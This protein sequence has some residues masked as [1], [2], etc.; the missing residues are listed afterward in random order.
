MVYKQAC[1]PTR[2]TNHSTSPAGGFSAPFTLLLSIL[3]SVFPPG[4]LAQQTCTWTGAVSEAFDVAG[5]WSPAVV[6]GP[7]DTAVLNSG[8]VTVATGSTVKVGG[9]YLANAVV[10]C[11]DSVFFSGNMYWSGGTWKGTGILTCPPGATLYLRG[12]STKMLDGDTLLNLGTVSWEGTGWIGINDGGNLMNYGLFEI[13]NNS[14]IYRAGGGHDCSVTNLAGGIIRKS[15]DG[16]TIFGQSLV[17]INDGLFEVLNGSVEI[18]ANGTI[19][20]T[21]EVKNG[22][23]LVLTLGNITWTSSSLLKS[24][25]EVTLGGTYDFGGTFDV[26][27]KTSVN[28][29]SSNFTGTV[30]SLGDTL[31]IS[32]CYLYFNAGDISVPVIRMTSG[33][34]G[35]SADVRA[36][37]EFDWLGGT[38]RDTGS[39]TIP[40]DGKMNISGDE[41]K[42]ATDRTFNNLGTVSWEGNGWIWVS[43]GCTFNNSGLFEIRNATKYLMGGGSPTHFNNLP[44]GIVRKTSAGTTTFS[45]QGLNFNNQGLLDLQ[46]GTLS[47]LT[48]AH[49]TGTVHSDPGTLISI[50]LG[51]HDFDP[52]VILNLQGGLLIKGGTARFNTDYTLPP[53]TEMT[54]GELSGSGTLTVTDTLKWTGGTLSDTGFLNV[55]AGGVFLV[56]GSADKLVFKRRI[57]NAGHMQVSEGYFIMTPYSVIR[58]QGD[59]TFKG[60]VLA[61]VCCGGGP[62]AEFDNLEG[63]RMLADASGGPVTVQGWYMFNEGTVNIEGSTFNFHP[64]Q[65]A[66]VYTQLKGTTHLGGG[67]FSAPREILIK[68]GILNGTGRITGN[69]YNAG[70]LSPGLSDS[71]PGSLTISG[72][73]TQDTTGILQIGIGGRS[74]VSGYDQLTTGTAVLAGSLQLNYTRN[75]SPVPQD[76][77]RVVR[78]IGQSYQGKF[79]TI[80]NLQYEPGNFLEVNYSSNN[81]MLSGNLAGKDVWVQVIGPKYGRPSTSTSVKIIYGNESPDTIVFPLMIEFRDIDEFKLLFD[82]LHFPFWIPWDDPGAEQAYL[83]GVPDIIMNDE[84]G[85]IPLI[86]TIPGRQPGESLPE[87]HE[88]DAELTPKCNGKAELTVSS[89]DPLTPEIEDCL[90]GI[91]GEL[92]G[93]LPGGPCVKAGLHLVLSGLTTNQ[94]IISGEPRSLGNWITDNGWSIAHCAVSLVPGLSLVAKVAQVLDEIVTGAGTVSTLSGCAAALLP[95]EGGQQSAIGFQCVTSK[96]PNLKGGPEGSGIPNYIRGDNP[97]AYAVYFE[98]VDTATAPAQKV[99]IRDTLRTGDWDPETFSFVSISFGDTTVHPPA[100]AH[101][102]YLEVDLRPARDL[103]VG[104]TGSL[105]DETGALSWEFVSLD[106]ATHNPV[107]DPLA[108]FLLP[109]VISPEGEGNVVFI[110]QPNLDLPTGSGIGSPASIVFDNNEAMVTNEWVNHLDRTAPSSSMESL[111]EIQVSG[112]FEL[113]WTGSDAHSGIRKYF[114]YVST[115]G[116]PFVQWLATGETSCMFRGDTCR[117]YSFYILA[118]DSAG[119]REPE[120][121][122][123]V[124]VTI[125]PFLQPA[126]EAAGNAAICEGDS[127]LLQAGFG[128]SGPTGGSTGEGSPAQLFYEWYRDNQLLSDVHGSE[129]YAHTA[130]DY[131]VTAGLSETCS[132]TSDPVTVTV[133]QAPDAVITASV[134]LLETLPGQ[135]AYQW[136]FNSSP[137][138][139]A[140]SYSYRAEVS[141]DYR[142]SVT[143]PNGCTALS[144][145]YSHIAIAIE[146]QTFGHFMVFPNP[147]GERLFIQSGNQWEGELILRITDMKGRIV[148]S[149]ET[150]LSHQGQVLEINLSGLGPGNYN[151]RIL[152]AGEVRNFLFSK[153]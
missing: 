13:N 29:N 151:L 126:L 27:K 54:G 110:V 149:D 36:S 131:S 118:Q 123:E 73:Y 101:D 121:D 97:L 1:S 138:A 82:Y 127:V 145:V 49:Y 146:D 67:E 106:P 70:T 87:F 71:L 72:R 24:N 28:G 14:A 99:V 125:N 33:N 41:T 26:L 2:G 95:Q 113:R 53:G 10:T 117:D 109:N 76:K 93:F 30:T 66:G 90:V 20:G 64:S 9:I 85:S 128:E 112:D 148:H 43:N 78:W 44:E 16:Q 83:N 23:P 75:Y 22:S 17:L 12:S 4:I 105:D 50:E 42:N 133:M 35:G 103:I 141:G 136:Y 130:G 58:N 40:A 140:T 39:I 51:T 37:I 120:K 68:G 61:G 139:G 81:L 8:Y 143:G 84:G 47:L 19:G 147:A 63:G 115:D 96:D 11:S 5:N 3:L 56:S 21:V 65:V 107:T 108:G 132:G 74:P 7:A 142:V 88:L 94:D 6:P 77:F 119:N 152:H 60:P 80:T 111:D 100:Y 129:Y 55:D 25:G 62:D 150:E 59:F 89:G 122:P 15:S 92:M 116:G 48:L 45:Q 46:E 34:L 102:F 38:I 137:I 124:H 144:E 32:S 52:G 114:L 104:I 18:R 79:D 86:I 31:N 135:A 134:N 98:N 153:Q 69:L 57:V 91:A